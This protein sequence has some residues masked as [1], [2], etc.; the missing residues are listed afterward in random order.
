MK[1]ILK[2]GVTRFFLQLIPEKLGAAE[3]SRLFVKTF[4]IMLEEKL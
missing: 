4:K 1:L 2:N 3:S